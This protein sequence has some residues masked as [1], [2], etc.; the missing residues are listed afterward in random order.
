MLNPKTA[1]PLWPGCAILVSVLVLIPTRIWPAFMLVSFAGFV[2]YDLQG[3]VPMASAA[4]FIPADTIQVLIAAF[5][6]RYFFDGVPRL[7]NVRSFAKYSFFA[8][9][10]GPLAA[11]FLSACGILGNY[12][13]SWRIAFLSEVLAFLTLTPAILSWIG[14]GPAWARKPRAYHLEFAALTAALFVLGYFTFAASAA[15]D[16]PALLYSLVPFLLWSTLRFGS[17]GISNSMIVIGF[18][19]VWGAVHG[20]GPFSQQLSQSRMLSL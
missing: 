10:L 4:W 14:E 12:W 20:R 7:N 16:S 8:V 6:L 1:W 15:G 2:L 5:G 9:F 18:L 11:A 17:F 3:G 13:S 19:A